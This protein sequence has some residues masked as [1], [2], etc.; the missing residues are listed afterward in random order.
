MKKIKLILFFALG[1]ALFSCE[2][3]TDIIQPGEFGEAATFQSV[4][5]MDRFLHGDVYSSV[6]MRPEVGFTSIFTDE[7]GI[8]S[9]NAGQNLDL[10]K[11][12]LTNNDGFADQ[13]WA[14]N[15]LTVNRVARLIRG[16]QRINP[17]ADEQ[18]RYNSIIAEAKALRAFANLQLLAYFSED[19][20]NDSSQGVILLDRV[21]SITEE[22]PRNTT[23]EI[24]DFIESDLTDAEANIVNHTGADAYFYVSTNMITALRARMYAY[25]GDYPQ[26]LTYA[27]QAIDNSGLTLTPAGTYTTSTVFYNPTTTTSPY[28]KMWADELQ[29]EIIFGL[30]R[31]PPNDGAIA[32]LYYTNS[33]K[34]S[35]APLHDMGRN[36]FN[37]LADQNQDGTISNP[38]GA[39]VQGDHDIRSRAF[40]DPTS[41]VAANPETVLT[42][43]TGDVLCIDKYPGK[44]GTGA[45]L[46]NN[47]KVFRLSE[48]FLIKA[49]A[50]ASSGD[51]AGVAAVLKQ[52]RDVRTFATA[53]QPA[54]PQPLPDYA[55]NTSAAWADIL[56][57]RR[58]EL[59]FEGHRYID[60]RRL[61]PLANNATIDR[62]HRD[63]EDNNL[64]QCTVPLGDHRYILPIPI[65][66]IIGNSNIQQNPEY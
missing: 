22:L 39:P 19:M 47:Q 63:C 4:D 27:Q 49:E 52:I 24:F 36:L 61:G 31:V 59:C 8:G 14:A 20:K 9:S 6:S 45:A 12:F 10:Y 16:A 3:A 43:K 42:W 46:I 57:E 23:G 13:I 37:L 11:F 53:S 64:P 17:T 32:N 58:K 26:A 55:G 54:Q 25:R 18:A 28:R 41:V 40:L 50:L 65:A 2:D 60:L 38:V 56:L 51:L 15:Y 7:V 62:F 34:I 33:T 21:P 48:M 30:S 35:G 44:T 1:A 66:E 29:G 5:D